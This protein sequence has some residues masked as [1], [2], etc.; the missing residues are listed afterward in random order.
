VAIPRG[1]NHKE[2]GGKKTMGLIEQLQEKLDVATAER[3]KLGAEIRELEAEYAKLYRQEVEVEQKLKQAD[4]AETI[5]AA[6][7]E[8]LELKR[9]QEEKLRELEDLRQLA[10]KLKEKEERA[11]REHERAVQKKRELEAEIKGVMSKI[12]RYRDFVREAERDLRLRQETL[13]ELTRKLERLQE[14]LASY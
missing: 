2:Q 10:V 11:K 12:E 3:R 1:I 5:R 6:R 7:Q 8:L 9:C 13:N 14:Q 4:T